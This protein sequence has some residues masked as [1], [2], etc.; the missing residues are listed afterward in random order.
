MR[1]RLMI[2]TAAL[3]LATATLAG[4]Q[5]K[6]QPATTS[7]SGTIDIGGRFTTTD[8]D[9]A[10]YERYRDLRDGVNAN[11]LYNR[12]TPNWTFDFLAKNIGY[13]DG[14]YQLFFNS[15]RVKLNAMFDQTPLNYAYYAKTPFACTAGSCTLDAGLRTQVQAGQAVGIPQN[16]GQLATGSVYNSIARPF[17]MQSRRD[18]LAAELRIS[19]TDNLDLIFGVN[20]YKRTG[21]MP[22]GASFA[23]NVATELPIVID[24][25]ETELKAGI[26]WAS[27][28][29]MF[30]VD[31]QHSKFNQTVPSF[32]F[33]NP[34]RATDFCRYGN[35]A[36]PPGTCYDPSGYTNGNGPAYGR[37]A[38]PPSNTLDTVNW[39]GMVKLPG[40]T[41]ANASFTMGANHQD[42]EL[43]A[44]TTNSSINTAAVW[45]AFPELAELPRDTAQMRVNYATGT[46]NVSS[47]A[48]KN[49]TLAARYRFNSRN[50]F[51]REFEGTEY[52]RFDAVPEETG[53]PTEAFNINRNTIDVSA[54]YTGISYSTIRVG[55][56]YDQ[57][58]HGVRATQGWKDGTARISYDLV[59]HQYVTLRA[60]YEHSKRDTINLSVDDIAGSGGQP[61]LRF[62]DEAARK[63]D[64]GTFIVSLTPV[65]SVGIDFSLATGKDDYEGADSTQEFGLL[66]NKNT[67][68]TAG[69]NYTPNAR[70]NVGAEYGHEKYDSLA[71]SRNANPAP[72]PSWT[73]PNRNW[74]MS[75]D[76]KVNY[77]TAYVNLVKALKNTDIRVAYDYS[78]SDQAFVHGGPRIAALAAA[79]TF[80]ALPNVTNKWHHFTVD[81][82]YSVS[83]NF[84]IG[85]YYLFEKFDVS[86]FA[87]INTAG[88]QTLPRPELGS[89]TDTARIDWLGSI[90]TGYAARPYKGQT[91][92]VRVFYNF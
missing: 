9:E 17:D 14:R 11:F 35:A 48:I 1:N 41:T 64:R 30:H 19:A 24:N 78:D 46:A 4:A 84:G 40:R 51:T 38:Q 3:L 65:S 43:I 60:L 16:V 72:D 54:A 26:E 36:N 18:T 50:D 20:S 88:P 32:T 74:T 92:I 70:V 83:K 56:N 42:A 77:F 15:K 5:D 91:G 58:E 69:V 82:A 31:Y 8:G 85:F 27:H 33:D 10:R 86:D 22:Y 7:S 76:E 66:N 62:Y 79:N 44:W 52:V 13:R 67:S 57:W 80:V 29:G 89:Q 49:L 6:P 73:D 68:W 39:M 90:T 81:I 61:A 34:Q 28:Q 12:E 87:T 21:D 63:R 47:R 55:Y 23:F 45:A 2:G 71:Q 59:G 53:G 25:R 75:N 37:M